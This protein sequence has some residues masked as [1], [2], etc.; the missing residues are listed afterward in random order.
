MIADIHQFLGTFQLPSDISQ[1]REC[2]TLA[3]SSSQYLDL[4]QHFFPSAFQASVERNKK[5]SLIPLPGH[6]YTIFEVQFLRLV[7]QHLFP[8]P[9]YVFD[10]PCEENRCLG[11]PIEPYG[12][13]PIYQY[14]GVGDAFLDM[15]LGW[16]LLFYLAGELSQEFFDG[17]IDPPMDSILE[18]EI[19]G[20][21][22]R[23]LLQEQ[24]ETREGPLSFLYLAIAMIDH[25]T[26]TA[27]LDATYDMPI[28][29]ARWEREVVEELVSQFVEAEEIW[30]KANQFVNWLEEDILDR[31]T[32]VV[33]LWN[34]C[35]TPPKP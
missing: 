11:V 10:D 2:I 23:R 6:A 19:N 7:N 15:D 4:Y 14:G 18:L 5:H 13:E 12:L 17:V 33:D 22:N 29:D 1:A 3:H 25:D 30:Q 34:R 24:C 8:I 16:Q 21:V 27:W 32:E 9:E 26:G 35:I 20:R 31:F 28:D